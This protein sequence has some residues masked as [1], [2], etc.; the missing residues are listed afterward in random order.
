MGVWTGVIPRGDVESTCGGEVDDGGGRG[1]A[2]HP[3]LSENRAAL[4]LVTAVHTVRHAVTDQLVRDALTPH[5]IMVMTTTLMMMIM[6]V[7]IMIMMMMII[8]TTTTTTTT[9]IIMVMTI[10]RT[11]I[12]L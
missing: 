12:I 9:I 4:L 7:I 6:I 10:M 3:V 5:S 2:G 1:H 11:K 8:T